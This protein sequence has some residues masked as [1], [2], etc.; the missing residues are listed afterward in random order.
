M[1]KSKYEMVDGLHVLLGTD[2]DVDVDIFNDDNEEHVEN[3]DGMDRVSI[4]DCSSLLENPDGMDRVSI[5]DCSS[6]LTSIHSLYHS[7]HYLNSKL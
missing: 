4:I 6:L 3:P 2:N 5:I 7:F 1:L